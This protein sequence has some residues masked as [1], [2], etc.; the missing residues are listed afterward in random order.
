PDRAKLHDI[1]SRL[2]F[3]SLMQEYLPEAPRA[4]REFRIAASAEE[5]RE[6]VQGADSI[7]VWVEPQ[8]IEGFDAPLAVSG[9]VK[10]GESLIV[11]NEDEFVRALQ[12]LFDSDRTFITYDAKAQERRLRAGG[13]PVPKRWSDVMLMSY[14]INPGLP[15]HALPNIARDRLKLD[16]L[17]RKEVQK[18]APLFALDHEV[19]SS[20]LGPL[21]QYLGEKS[22]VTFA[23]RQVLEPELRKDAAL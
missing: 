10:P 13:L 14:V 12:E 7:A 6:Y 2:E 4:P 3:A 8:T 1:F 18:T 9:T 21:Q 19:G 11:P 23:L 16:V 15:S 5:V 20:K 22:D 17:A